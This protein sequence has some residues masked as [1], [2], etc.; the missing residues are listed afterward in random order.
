MARLSRY[1]GKFKSI[2]KRI[3]GELLDN[4]RPKSGRDTLF[5]GLIFGIISVLLFYFQWG[6]LWLRPKLLVG[7]ICFVF[8]G[9][10]D[11]LSRRLLWVAAVLRA[12]V[13]IFLV[14]LI[15]WVARDLVL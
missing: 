7:A 10:A 5:V 15:F 14:A 1:H 8:W 12:T 6:E 4:P 13:L 3:K 2:K 11:L 9:V